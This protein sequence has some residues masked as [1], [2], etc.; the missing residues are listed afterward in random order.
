MLSGAVG[1]VI[2]AIIGGLFVMRAVQF[3]FKRQSEAACRAL[4][5]ENSKRSHK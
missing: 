2:G 3:Q 1:A 4:R 5:V